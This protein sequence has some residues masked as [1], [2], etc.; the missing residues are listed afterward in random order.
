MY[1]NFFKS[2]FDFLASLFGI[3]IIS[4][5]LIIV[6]LAL[7]FQNKGT[8]FFLQARPG[9]NQ[10]AFKI[11]KFKTMTDQRD[12]EGHLLPDNQR[13]TRLG[14]VIRKLSI[15]EL[16]Q[17]INVIKADMSLVGPR[18]L[19]F[20]YIP[21]YSQEQLRRHEVRPGITGWAQVNG[22]NSISWTKKFALD[23]EYVDKMSLKLDIK[24][25]YLTIIKVIKKEGVNEHK[26]RP[27][28]PFNGVN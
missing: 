9:K 10:K 19:L 2:L 15:D 18:P 28:Q 8:P 24:I 3:I 12:E 14:K 4:P 21:L 6:A 13:I 22:R 26:E 17:L 1:K 11:I 20:K 16:P 27:M 25:L 5:I 7:A 23:I